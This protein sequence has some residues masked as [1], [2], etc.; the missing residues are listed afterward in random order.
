[1]KALLINP[2][3]RT[4]TEVEYSGDFNGPKGAYELLK[5]DLVELVH[6][7]QFPR[8]N[9]ILVDEE[10]LY[11]RPRFAWRLM[12]GKYDA[13]VGRGLTTAI[14][15]SGNEKESTIKIEDLKRRVQWLGE[16]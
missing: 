15:S 4:I 10:G 6:D 16:I 2:E 8:S 12:G 3:D 11:K 9:N 1:M 5:C 13:L 7:K 14:A